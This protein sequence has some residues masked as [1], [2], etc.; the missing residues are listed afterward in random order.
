MWKV[1]K[2]NWWQRLQHKCW[3]G[4]S[5]RE[6]EGYLQP[7]KAAQMPPKCA[8]R[9]SQ[10]SLHPDRDTACHLSSSSPSL[11]WL[12]AQ[13]SW[14]QEMCAHSPSHPAVRGADVVS[15]E[16][17]TKWPSL[18]E[19]NLL[20]VEAKWLMGWCGGWARKPQPLHLQWAWAEYRALSLW[21]HTKETSISTR[22]PVLSTHILWVYPK[23]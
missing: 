21:A 6:R 16:T 7:Y 19:Q 9:S 13:Q 15:S 22:Y 8:A 23:E 10:P 20:G 17:S 11:K 5:L 1:F 4:V 18:S 14:P 2:C 3:Q 12:P